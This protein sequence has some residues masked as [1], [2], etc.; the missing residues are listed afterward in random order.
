MI[1]SIERRNGVNKVV[2]SRSRENS[3]ENRGREDNGQMRANAQSS[4]WLVVRCLSRRH[5]WANGGCQ[6]N[7]R[8]LS[9]LNLLSLPN[10]YRQPGNITSIPRAI[11]PSRSQIT[12]NARAIHSARYEKHTGQVK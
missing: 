12:H 10:P 5:V 1:L 4:H 11:A 8:S 7:N 3:K 2:I 9:H 6:I